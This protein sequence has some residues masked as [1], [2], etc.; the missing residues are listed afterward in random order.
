MRGLLAEVTHQLGLPVLVEIKA[1]AS[2][3]SVSGCGRALPPG[4]RGADGGGGDAGDHGAQ[5]A[6]EIKSGQLYETCDVKCS[7]DLSVN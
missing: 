2:I 7:F 1:R 4:Q 3:I 6:P 5:G